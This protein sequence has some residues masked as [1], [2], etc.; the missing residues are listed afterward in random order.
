MMKIH[1]KKYSLFTEMNNETHLQDAIFSNQLPP[2]DIFPIANIEIYTQTQIKAAY[3]DQL[4]I[5]DN[6]IADLSAKRTETIKT[7]ETHEIALFK[8]KSLSA[9]YRRIP[10]EIINE[11]FMCCIP[12]DESNGAPNLEPWFNALQIFTQVCH[13]WSD[14]AKNHPKIWKYLDLDLTAQG[15]KKAIYILKKWSYIMPV[16]NLHLRI[17]S[18]HAIIM[19]PRAKKLYQ[20]LNNNQR[21]Q[22][23][24]LTVAGLYLFSHLRTLALNFLPNLEKFQIAELGHIFGPETI[25]DIPIYLHAPKLKGLIMSVTCITFMD[26]RNLQM[27]KCLSLKSNSHMIDNFLEI[28]HKCP[29][30]TECRINMTGIGTSLEILDENSPIVSLCHL[31]QFFLFLHEA[32]PILISKIN[33]PEITTLVVV[34]QKGR[35][36]R[37]STLNSIVPLIKYTKKLSE[38]VILGSFSA[39]EE[40]DFKHIFQEIHPGIPHYW[41]DNFKPYTDD[42]YGAF[43]DTESSGLEV[44]DDEVEDNED[45][46][47]EII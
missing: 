39:E 35:I 40:T 19:M 36:S 8:L 9:P 34:K 23:L 42:P 46:N 15:L 17:N 44:E 37:N 16:N 33:A 4:A 13:L 18:T 31:T 6:I 30:L 43:S 25:L 26:P 11:I 1:A 24:A 12:N 41:F 14:I 22:S 28:L 32:I 20:I 5:I 47:M 7:I 38:L 45:E 29:N 3:D 27:I 10:P 2:S 21:L